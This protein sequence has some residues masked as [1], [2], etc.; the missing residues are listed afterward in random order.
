M[1]SYAHRIAMAARADG[2]TIAD[3]RAAAC[4][5]VTRRAVV[6]A[7]AMMRLADENSGTSD[8]ADLARSVADAV[9]GVAEKNTKQA[10]EAQ[11]RR[12]ARLAS[13]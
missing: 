13:K 7:D 8:A 5:E 2:M 9:Y 11:K 10:A 6:F 3:R 1:E 12:D 4:A